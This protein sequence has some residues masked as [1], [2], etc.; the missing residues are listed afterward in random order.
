L[1]SDSA[2]S[3]CCSLLPGSVLPGSD[4]LC[5][6]TDHFSDV[7]GGPL[8][9]TDGDFVPDISDNCPLAS[10][11]DQKDTTGAPMGDACNCALPGVK[12]GPTGTACPV[13][14]VPIPTFA[15]VLMAAALGLAGVASLRFR[16]RRRPSR[17]R[18]AA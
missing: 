10:N 3:K 17:Q 7:A 5:A 8:A 2:G 9:D 13:S 16:R 12:F 11:L 18:P 4:P 6:V 1:V 14:A 15:V